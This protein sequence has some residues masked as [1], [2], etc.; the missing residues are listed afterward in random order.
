MSMAHFN[1]NITKSNYGLRL[2]CLLVLVSI[3]IPMARAEASSV[4]APIRQTAPESHRIIVKLQPEAARQDQFGSNSLQAL[5]AKLDV[6]SIAPLFP[7][8]TA[9]PLAM[10]R[11]GFDRLYILELPEST[12]VTH[13]VAEFSLDSGVEYAEIDA[14]GYGTV[15]PNDSQ[16]A[17]QW[18]LNNTGQ[19]GCKLDADID[20]PEAWNL[21]QGHV[22]TIVAVIDSGVDLD[23]PDLAG[24]ILAGYDYVNN[25]SNP[26][27][28]HGHGT[29]VSGTAAASSNNTVGVSGICWNCRI[30]PL[31][32]LDSQNLGF[33][34][35]WASSLVFAAD[36]G[37]SVI[38]M[39]MGGSSD[40]ITLHD[41][42]RYAYRKNIPITVAM[43]NTGNSTPFYPA[44]YPEVIAIGST[45]CFD[46]RSN[47]S[48]FGSHID[49]AAPGSD[50]LSTLW[51]N[52]YASWFGTSMA[53][54]HVTGVIGLLRSINPAYSAAELASILKATAD[55]QVGPGIEDT[56][57]WDPYFGSG[58]LNAFKAVQY[59]SN[60]PKSAYRSAG[61]QDGW[62]LESA[63]TSNQGGTL[64]AAA[65]LLYV[66]DNAKDRQFKS[67]LSFNTA[68]L[69]DNAVIIKAQLRIYYEGFAGT[70]LFS[71]AKTH[72]NLLVDIRKP[73]FGTDLSLLA[74]DFQAAA[75]KNAIGPLAS[76]PAPGWVT[77]KLT[78]G[79][80]PSVN[81]TGF[82]QIRLRFQNDDND[83]LQAD[84]L[85]FASGN[86]A[87]AAN[88]PALIIEYYVP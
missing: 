39:S 46:A 77:I 9:S 8:G 79:T 12:D 13:A 32:A 50:I 43:M 76:A 34:S 16:F 14:I 21:N 59:V 22:N 2:I 11:F 55:D 87:T 81:R 31:K 82:T 52:T 37:A 86:A 66:G 75:S 15:T 35:W 45:D 51:N 74:T 83:D 24:K 1:A 60:P 85:K 6:R 63:E 36:H 19:N 17:T 10:T 64:N 44:A 62:L 38:N 29:H 3:S 23:H 68:N 4:N 73:Y 70:N 41:A 47:F 65:P 48:N 80:F 57:G 25:D 18:S 78:A 84:F 7:E 27:D 67:I 71:P 58:R 42:I 49:L 26:S 72:G 61:T 5:T 40:S 30:M 56:P 28:D 88:R 53:T 20:A 33:Y 69:P 54:P